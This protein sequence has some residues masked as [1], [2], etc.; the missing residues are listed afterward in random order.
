MPTVSDGP[1]DLWY[2]VRGPDPGVSPGPAVVLTGGFGLLHDQFHTVV[3][4]LAERHTVVNWHYRGCGRSTRTG[5]DG[6]WTVDR[7]AD[8]LELVL[9]DAG[10]PDVVLWGTSTGSSISARYAGRHPERVRALVMH[11][12]I[13]SDGGGRRVFDG[14]EAVAR[15][16]GYEALALTSAW[17][18]CAGEHDLQPAMLDLARFEIGSFK[19][20]FGLDDLPAILGAFDGVDVS[21]DLRR[22]TVPVL[23]LLGATGRMGAERSGTARAVAELQSLVPHAEVAVIPAGGGTYCMIEQPEATLAALE[24]FLGRL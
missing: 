4:T 15:S 1:V 19:A 12:F 18:G 14:F 11:P 3:D 20:N 5:P 6:S 16:F 22:T 8:D 13:R 21:D 23:A 24:A 9:A 2:E 10:L 17:I 7:W